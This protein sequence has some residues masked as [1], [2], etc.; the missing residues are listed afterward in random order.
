MKHITAKTIRC[1][2]TKCQE[3]YVIPTSASEDRSDLELDFAVCPHCRH[4]RNP[5]LLLKFW[6][7]KRC[8]GCKIPFEL[9]PEN[10][11]GLCNSCYL[12]LMKQKHIYFEEIKNVPL[13]K[14][15]I[16]VE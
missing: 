1:G 10:G 14:I 16:I 5:D 13:L 8:W 15:N 9:K 2:N 11:C 7:K 3:L 4:A 6:G 12:V